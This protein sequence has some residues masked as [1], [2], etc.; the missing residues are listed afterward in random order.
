MDVWEADELSLSGNLLL[1]FPGKALEAVCGGGVV[2]HGQIIVPRGMLSRPESIV[3]LT[4]L[5]PRG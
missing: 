3:G 4:G 1:H 2:V 5:N